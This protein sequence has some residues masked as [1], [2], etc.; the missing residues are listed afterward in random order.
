[1]DL[2]APDGP[3]RGQ[4]LLTKL[5]RVQDDLITKDVKMQ[6]VRVLTLAT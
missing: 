3:R 6:N 4:V 1:V 5:V 2:P